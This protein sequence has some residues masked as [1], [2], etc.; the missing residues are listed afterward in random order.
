MTE[1][2]PDISPE[3]KQ[4]ITQ[5][6]LVSDT[7]PLAPDQGSD[8]YIFSFT[9]HGVLT[10]GTNSK[11]VQ[12]RSAIA[13]V[14]QGMWSKILSRHHVVRKVVQKTK[15]EYS[16][17]GTVEYGLVNGK[18]LIVEWTSEMNFSSEKI[19]LESYNVYLDMSPVV[20]ALG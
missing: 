1:Y 17:E 14:R 2:T 7:K 15:Q 20:A 12:G 18:S 4:F 5:F 11:P 19:Q 13:E 9:K 3:I 16:L 8:P 6:F 10:M